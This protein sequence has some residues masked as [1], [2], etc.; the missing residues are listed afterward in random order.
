M[1]EDEDMDK[2]TALNGYLYEIDAPI[3]Y[4][5]ETR[6]NLG[7]T[8]IRMDCMSFFPEVM[9]NDIRR[10][11]LKDARHQWVHFPDNTKYK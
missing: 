4:N 2:R 8:R 3:A 10:V 9:N 5:E 11:A 7:R 6:D 1:R